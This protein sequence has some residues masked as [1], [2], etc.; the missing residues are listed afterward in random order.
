VSLFPKHRY[1]KFVAIANVELLWKALP[2][3]FFQI[4]FETIL[5]NLKGLSHEMDLA[6]EDILGDAASF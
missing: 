1:L 6:L 4:N 2:L 5:Y 3:I